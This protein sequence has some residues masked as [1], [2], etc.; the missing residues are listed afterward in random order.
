MDTAVTSGA[1]WIR[2]LAG[3]RRVGGG[4]GGRKTIRREGLGEGLGSREGGFEVRRVGMGE[5]ERMYQETGVLVFAVCLFVV[6]VF[7]FIC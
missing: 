7:L 4:G 3:S 2:T 6:S 1:A 5:G